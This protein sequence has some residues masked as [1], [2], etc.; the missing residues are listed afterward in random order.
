MSLDK[1]SRAQSL[2]PST[3][4]TGDLQRS[5]GA[6]AQPKMSK[7]E[8]G[9]ILYFFPNF[10]AIFLPRPDYTSSS[11]Y[12]R[13]NL[14]HTVM[15]HPPTPRHRIV[16]EMNGDKFARARTRAYEIIVVHIS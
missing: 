11:R 5:E 3:A 13:R 7:S 16:N 9:T 15:R 6:F 10:S 14:N 12:P 1:S 2:G 8:K 4:S